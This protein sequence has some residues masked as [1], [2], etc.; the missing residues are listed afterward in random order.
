MKNIAFLI[1]HLQTNWP[2]SVSIGSISNNYFV[3]Y[4]A[5]A[6]V[7]FHIF[8]ALLADG[9]TEIELEQIIFEF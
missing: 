1:S 4:V 8:R 2:N 3:A 6:N 5:S 9:F 7:A